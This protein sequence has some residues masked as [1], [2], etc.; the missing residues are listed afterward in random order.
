MSIGMV[1]MVLVASAFC[2]AESYYED[3]STKKDWYADYW[4]RD[5][6]YITLSVKETS[7]IDWILCSP[8]A[9]GLVLPGDVI[10]FDMMLV[11]GDGDSG[12]G[13]AFIGLDGARVEFLLD[14]DGWWSVFSGAPDS[15]GL[16]R[17]GK[18]TKLN[19]QQTGKGK[20]HTIRAAINAE[21]AEIYV[22][23]K[24]A[25]S[26]TFPFAES[27]AGLALT[28]MNV[29]AP[30]TTARFDNLEIMHAQRP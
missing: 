12:A 11:H 18:V 16:T 9:T 6:G 23:G 17:V 2:F 20:H 1:L 22:D 3:F 15:T 5:G 27:G 30:G 4:D 7:T 10:E 24:K 8:E 21:H 26:L 28:V 29:G 19:L 13:L 25:T 14:A